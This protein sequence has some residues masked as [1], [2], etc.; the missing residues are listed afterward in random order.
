MVVMPEARTLVCVS[1]SQFHGSFKRGACQCSSVVAMTE[2]QILVY[3]TGMGISVTLASVWLSK[4]LL[5]PGDFPGHYRVDIPEVRTHVTPLRCS[6]H[7]LLGNLCAW[8]PQ[9]W[10]EEASLAF[11]IFNDYIS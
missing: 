11:R 2:A 5:R 4:L 9:F 10:F 7:Y 3:V 6:L 8:T 1:C